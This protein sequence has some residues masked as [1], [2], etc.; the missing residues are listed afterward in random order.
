MRT[1]LHRE[2]T[3]P[4]RLKWMWRWCPCTPCWQRRHPP[5][6]Y[7]SGINMPKLLALILEQGFDVRPVDILKRDIAETTGRTYIPNTRM[8]IPNATEIYRERKSYS[9][10]VFNGSQP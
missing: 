6:R 1:L 2:E 8:Q 7:Q 3:G 4:V 9:Y 10:G 5:P